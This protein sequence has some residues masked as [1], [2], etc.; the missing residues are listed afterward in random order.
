[1]K[2]YWIARGTSGTGAELRETPTPKP[3]AGA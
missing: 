1:M 2:A 3:K